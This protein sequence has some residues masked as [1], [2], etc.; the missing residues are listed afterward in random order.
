MMHDRNDGV[1]IR[2]IVVVMATGADL[3]IGGASVG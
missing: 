1:M 3:V 2:T